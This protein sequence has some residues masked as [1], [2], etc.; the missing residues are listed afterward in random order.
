MKKLHC[1]DCVV[2]QSLSRRM[3]Q[4]FI[5]V[6]SLYNVLSNNSVR[7][8]IW[9]SFAILWTCDLCQS[10][11]VYLFQAQ[12]P[13]N[14]VGLDSCVIAVFLPYVFKINLCTVCFT[15][16]I[17]TV[18]CSNKQNLIG[19]NKESMATKLTTTRRKY[20]QSK[21]ALGEGGPTGSC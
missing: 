4:T 7:E 8:L 10:I 16:R 1:S 17:A 19:H 13:Y 11:K 5:A 14:R 3:H 18:W 2:L 15:V 20:L 12:G 21:S 9:N 6:G